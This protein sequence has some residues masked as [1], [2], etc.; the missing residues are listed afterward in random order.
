MVLD[1]G[2]KMLEM[3]GGTVY[4]ATNSLEI[5]MPEM[6]DIKAMNE[7]KEISADLPSYLGKVA[8]L[9]YSKEAGKI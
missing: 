8:Q 1:V 3:L 2:R 7:T 5:S 9:F 4:T 6:D